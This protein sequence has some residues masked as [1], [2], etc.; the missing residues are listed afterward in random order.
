[1]FFNIIFVLLFAFFVTAIVFAVKHGLDVD[2]I[3]ERINEKVSPVDESK[4]VLLHENSQF[5]EACLRRIEDIIGE[6][7]Y[8]EFQFL[9]N[10]GADVIFAGTRDGLPCVSFTMPCDKS[11]YKN[12][13]ISLGQVVKQYSKIQYNIANAPVMA[14]WGINRTLNLP[15]ICLYYAHNEKEYELFKRYIEYQRNII[16]DAHK[17]VTDDE[18][19]DDLNDE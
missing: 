15:Q 10:A 3:I 5:C 11:K 17:D 13:E 14:V 18:F 1:M 6:K 2:A 7:N 9:R 4:A 12:L 8:N 19:G 16:I